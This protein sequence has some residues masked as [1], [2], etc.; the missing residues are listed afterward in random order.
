M[1]V[2]QILH[3]VGVFD[4]KLLVVENID[5]FW[6]NVASDA[7]E[8]AWSCTG[9]RS[10]FRQWRFSIGGLGMVVVARGPFS[11]SCLGLQEGIS[12]SEK[13]RTA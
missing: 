2:H 8:R 1:F 7:W 12:A 3:Y 9:Q 11:A 4:K 10:R 5:L 13:K 6:H